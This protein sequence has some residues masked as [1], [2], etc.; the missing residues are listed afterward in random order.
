MTNMRQDANRLRCQG[1][2]KSFD[3]VQALDGVSLDFPKLG[4]TA[5]IGPN[6]AGK[7]TL[8]NVLTGFLR[9]DGGRCFSAS[10]TSRICPRV[11]SRNWESR[12]RFRNFV[13]SA[14]SPA[15][16]C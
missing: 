1:L 16:L 10:A 9:A 13:K 14:A 7:T 8:L 6:G 11:A 5:V 15:L 3:G 4:I 2:T 12:G